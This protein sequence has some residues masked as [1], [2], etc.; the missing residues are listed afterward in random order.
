MFE[1]RSDMDAEVMHQI[2]SASGHIV[3]DECSLDLLCVLFGSIY[4]NWQ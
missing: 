2:L 3:C 4:S 1:R